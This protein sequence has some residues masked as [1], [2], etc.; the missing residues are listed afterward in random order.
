LAAF[1]FSDT[2][3]VDSLCYFG[4][5]ICDTMSP[6]LFDRV[7]KPAHSARLPMRNKHYF[8]GL[9][10]IIAISAIFL[11][12]IAPHAIAQQASV[13]YSFNT[14]G[15]VGY[16]PT[17]AL[18]SD[19][20]GNLY[21]TTNRGGIYG[22]GTAFMLTRKAV[23]GWTETV[24]HEFGYGED[25][26][27]PIASL[28]FDASGN[29]YGVTKY[30]GAGKGGTAFELIPSASGEWKEIIIHNFDYDG[31][32]GWSPAGNLVID[33]AG[34][35]YGTTFSGGN[36]AGCLGGGCG[37]VY[38]LS[39]GSGGK[40]TETV[41]Y[42]APDAYH[43]PYPTGGLIFDASDNLYGADLQEVFE[44]TPSTGGAWT[45]T[46]LHTFTGSP[47]GYQPSGNLVFDAA[48]NLYGTTFT[49]GTG[50][51]TACDGEGCGT[52]FELSPSA[53]G[54]WTETI[55]HSF[56]ENGTDG[57]LTQEGVIL[58]ANGTLYGTTPFGGD[59]ANCGPE[60]ACG[61]VFAMVP[62]TGSGWTDEIL[63]NF[64]ANGEGGLE[65]D[66]ALIFGPGGDLYSTTVFGGSNAV[67]TVFAIKP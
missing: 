44:L 32:G 10:R 53:G 67:G 38:E 62:T 55:L 15:N 61:I 43:G 47:D 11:A 52:V 40:W 16:T 50:A 33:G 57:Y 5:A 35:L 30:G 7:T 26:Q 1:I 56:S 66:A 59:K 60:H 36:L 22:G 46:T 18:I 54:V 25:G 34:N 58:G 4:R 48:G 29:L 24:L 65:P 9:A 8:P 37:T 42:A 13:L 31:N 12:M 2:R 28:I 45:K 39:P 14:G 51:G 20:A 17:G 3:I 64:S 19:A 41:L 21:G 63:F 23:V 49:G 6:F 27:G